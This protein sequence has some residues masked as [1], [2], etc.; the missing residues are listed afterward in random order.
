[1][2]MV[3]KYHLLDNGLVAEEKGTLKNDK[4]MLHEA[5][6][7]LDPTGHPYVAFFQAITEKNEAIRQE[8]YKLARRLKRPEAHF[9]H[10]TYDREELGHNE[11]L[12]RKEDLETAATMGSSMALTAHAGLLIR[13]YDADIRNHIFLYTSHYKSEAKKLCLEALK[14]DDPSAYALAARMVK[15]G[16]MKNTDL[17]DDFYERAKALRCP[18]FGDQKQKDNLTQ[19]IE[20]LRVYGQKLLDEER[21]NP[22][23]Q[24]EGRKAV[25]L[26]AE[27]KRCSESFTSGENDIETQD[28]MSSTFKVAVLKGYKEFKHRTE[29]RSILLNIAICATGVGLLALG[30]QLA[31]NGRGF[32][33][34]TTRCQ[35][36][37]EIDKIFKEIDSDHYVYRREPGSSQG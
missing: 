21:D 14:L 34:E 37:K 12:K 28:L 9:F 23:S 15:K 13:I 32:F 30:A 16:L 20:A 11:Y 5:I 7:K 26:A 3:L 10:H 29:W 31:I 1:M 8:K 4:T 22:K 2:A 17:P 33:S 36:L 25:G 18:V 19:A 35:K 6:C 24:T 27:L